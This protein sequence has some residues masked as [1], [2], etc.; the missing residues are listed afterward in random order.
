MAELSE[1]ERE[2]LERLAGRFG[3]VDLEGRPDLPGEFQPVDPMLAESLEDPLESVDEADWIAEPKYDG[4]RLV[5]ETF[6]GDVRAFSRRGIDRYD[7]VGPVHE[8]LDALPDD[9]VFD[10]ELAFV[11]PTGR[12]TYQPIHSSQETLEARDLTPVYCVFDLLYDRDDGDVCDEPLMSRKDRLT[13]RL[14]A[15]DHKSRDRL[16]LTPYHTEDFQA[17]FDE[18]VDA[19]GEG[20]ML[21][22]RE[23]RYYRDVRSA[24]WLKVKDFSGRDAIVVGYTEGAGGRED[25]FGSL[26]LSDGEQCIGRV[27][28]GFT[29]A[30]LAELAAA[31][32]ETDDYLVSEDEA[33]EAYTPVEPFVVSVKY[34]EV[35]ETGKLRAPV[36]LGPKPEKPRSD[37]QPVT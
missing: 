20:I 34:Q 30:D 17:F 19:G 26:V 8:D 31:M 36:Y 24:Q 6:D 12:S 25:S 33:G 32:E 23:S 11:T 15:A 18:Y 37:V 1:A 13:D 21:K 16:E 10:G 27:G 9:C 5:V 22:R 28:S 4:T 3:D 29:E 2:E 35:T 14:A 7:D